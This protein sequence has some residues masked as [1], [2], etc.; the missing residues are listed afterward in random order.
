MTRVL[1]IRHGRT[2]WND[3]RRIQGH[4]DVSLSDAGRAE[5]RA[6]RLPVKYRQWPV[7]A[8]PLKRAVESVG[9]LGLGKPSLDARLMEMNYGNWEGAT[10]TELE[11][12]YGEALASRARRGLEFRPDG[13]ESPR[14]LKAR[15]ESWLEEI[16]AVGRDCVAVSHK[17]VI[18]MA[19]AL[20]TGWDLVSKAPQR[21]KWE[22]GHLFSLS[23]GEAGIAVKV[24]T[25]NVDLGPP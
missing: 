5:L 2:S 14:E 10:W 19:L 8:S 18:R 9:L 11:S 17:G 24:N 6:R 1:F 4:T 16:E 15:L 13:G 12:R 3:E 7:Y 23:G 22:R 20:A 21:L 25:L